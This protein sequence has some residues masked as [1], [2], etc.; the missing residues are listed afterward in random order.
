MSDK[1]W[2]WLNRRPSK[3]CVPYLCLMVTSVLYGMLLLVGVVVLV[4]GVGWLGLLTVLYSVGFL[5]YV[6]VSDSKEGFVD[7]CY[8]VYLTKRERL[9]RKLGKIVDEEVSK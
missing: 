6:Y 4:L 3:R 2:W 9:G 8:R 7:A 1:F 5:V